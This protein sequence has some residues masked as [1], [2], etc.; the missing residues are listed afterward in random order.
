MI[1]SEFANYAKFAKLITHH[2][3]LAWKRGEK[4]SNV[5]FCKLV[6]SLSG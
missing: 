3:S 4:I 6:E 1:N 5:V 2:N